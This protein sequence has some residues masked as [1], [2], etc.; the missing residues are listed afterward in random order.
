MALT[1]IKGSN[2]ADGTVEATD[3]DATLDLSSKSVTL[4]SGAVTAHSPVATPTTVSDQTNTSTGYLDL[5]SGTTAQR[6]EVPSDGMIR[7]NTTLGISEYY[8]VDEWKV[9]DNPPSITSVDV[10][11]VDSSSGN[12]TSFV[13]TGSNFASG[14]TVKFIGSDATEFS[15]ASVTLDSSS[16]ITAVVA[17]VNFVN[18]AEPYDIKVTN[19]SGM[20]ATLDNQINVDVGPSWTTPAGQVGG[21][22]YEGDTISF[23]L[24][25][26]DPDGDAITYTE[27]SSTLSGSGLS[28]ATNGTI[29]G[30]GATVAADTTY[31]FDARVTANSKTSDRTFNLVIK[32]D[33]INQIDYYTNYAFYQMNGNANDSGYGRNGTAYNMTYSSAEAKS[34]GF[35]QCGV[36]NSTSGYINT[37]WSLPSSP[38]FTMMLW[39]KTTSGGN[40]YFWGDV[41]GAYNITWTCY[42]LNSTSVRVVAD[43]PGG[44]TYHIDA[45]AGYAINDNTWHHLCVVKENNNAWSIYIDGALKGTGTAHHRTGVNNILIG[46]YSSSGPFWGGYLDQ[47]RCKADALSAGQVAT[48]YNFENNR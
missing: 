20:N 40:R 27:T 13:I 14:I 30:T 39:F 9:I 10:T 28:L 45:D 18:A 7:F 36:F 38:K 6:P 21:N 35:G 31:S 3:L 25:A 11:E 23:N 19:Q 46:A 15:A 29:S 41:G 5:P 47:I 8:A 43:G 44:P 34:A 24:A 37:G 32:D 48:V 22:L 4:A 12:N 17:D 26:T 1:R 33:H 42:L 16:Q 2:I